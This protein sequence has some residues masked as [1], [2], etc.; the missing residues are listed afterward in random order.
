MMDLFQL[1]KRQP[2]LVYL[3]LVIVLAISFFQLPG[4]LR[5]ASAADTQVETISL[6]A[7]TTAVTRVLHY[8]GRLMDPATKVPKPDGS[9]TMSFRLY[10]VA[11]AGAALWTENK[12]IAVTDGLFSTLL[13]DTTA[14]D[15]NHFNGDDLYLGVTVGADP[16]A[17]PR[18][19]LAY[20]AYALFS[21]RSAQADSADNAGNADK[22]DG[23]DSTAFAVAG[24]LHDD[25]Y[26]TEGETTSGFINAAGPDSMGGSS[27]SAILSVNQAGGG[28]AVQGIT[29]STASGKAGVYGETE[30]AGP[31]YVGSS[32][33]YGT[34]KNQRGVTG[35]SENAVGVLG[36]SNANVGV[37]GQSGSGTG[38][39]AFSSTGT[40][41]VAQGN[42]LVTGDLSVS[43]KISN[44][45]VPIAV[46]F[47][48]S[49]GTVNVGSGNISST[50][51]SGS[52]RYEITISG[53]SYFYNTY[54]T[55]ATTICDGYT[56]RTSSGSGKLFIYIR[57]A[58]NA[59]AT[60]D[61][62]FVTYKP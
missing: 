45:L 37:Y 25:R 14:L 17:T 55:T 50:Y 59:A 6:Q 47:I 39:H 4:S 12:S 23:N 44:P 34:S 57:N 22:L 32:G 31:N 7:D 40:A 43:G 24:H 61:F 8:Q 2:L 51:N 19:R 27:A 58:S 30:A 33:V 46:G 48:N 38:V 11:T 18:Q 56:I 53:Y 13:G 49:G 15:T 42:G 10:N 35:T 36:Y 1:V 5:M 16:E 28:S 60:C 41:L 21:V 3:I 52:S 26:F 9:Y 62:Q 20:S 54:V 29:A